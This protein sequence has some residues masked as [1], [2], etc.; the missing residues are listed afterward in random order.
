MCIHGD[1]GTAGLHHCKGVL[2]GRHDGV[3]ANH[4]VSLGGIYFRGVNRIRTIGDLDMAPGSAAL[5]SQPACILRYHALAF[6]MRGHAQQLTDCDDASAAN[7]AHHNAPGFFS[8]RKHRL[9][10]RREA[11]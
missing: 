1:I 11:A 8:Q 9:R 2:A 5:L 4:Q 10:N 7:A 6:Q 3:A